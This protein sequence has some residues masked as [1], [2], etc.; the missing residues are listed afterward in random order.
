MGL[1][2]AP[3]DKRFE[4]VCMLLDGRKSVRRCDSADEPK[5]CIYRALLQ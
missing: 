1:S 2:A 5:T 3:H 4:Y